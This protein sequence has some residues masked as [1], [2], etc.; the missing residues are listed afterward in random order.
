MA[1][2]KAKATKNERKNEIVKPR[3]TDRGMTSLDPSASGCRIRR[4][5]VTPQRQR[6]IKVP[7]VRYQKLVTHVELHAS[8]VSLLES[9]ELR[10]NI[11]AINKKPPITT[12]ATKNTTHTKTKQVV[13]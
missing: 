13:L 1:K 4:C 8:A 6:I 10:F 2:A 11:K 3:P 9:G 7:L 5:P 12:T